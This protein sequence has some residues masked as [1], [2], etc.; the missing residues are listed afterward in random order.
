M[1]NET[2]PFAVQLRCPEGWEIKNGLAPELE[3]HGTFLPMDLYDLRSIYMDG[4]CI[5]YLGFCVFEPYEEEI[6][7]EEYYKTVW[8]G[9]RL[10]S[11]CI[12][13]PFVAV[14]EDENGACGMAEITYYEERGGVKTECRTQGILAYDKELQVYT[15]IAFLPGKVQET[16]LAALAD[17]LTFTALS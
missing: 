5:G 6:P 15:G 11:S 8:P 4:E 10:S 3:A 17:S 12:W 7:P 1:L 13:D 9:L 16:E 2:Q 14:R